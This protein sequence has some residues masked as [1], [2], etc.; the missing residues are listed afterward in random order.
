VGAKHAGTCASGA[1]LFIYGVLDFFFLFPFSFF[2]FHLLHF[3]E[4]G[5][6][7]K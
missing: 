5:T 3:N 1:V 4:K 2:Y 7:K 6:N